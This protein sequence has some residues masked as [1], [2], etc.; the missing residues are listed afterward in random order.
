MPRIFV[1]GVRGSGKSTLLEKIQ[2]ENYSILED[3]EEICR[4]HDIEKKSLNEL[5]FSQKEPML[6]ELYEEVYS[7]IVNLLLDSHFTFPDEKGDYRF[8]E[9]MENEW[10]D[11]FLIVRTN[12]ETLRKRMLEDDKIRSWPKLDEIE[13]Y[14]EKEEEVAR[15]IADFHGKQLKSIKNNGSIEEGKN[16]LEKQIKRID[17]K[18][19]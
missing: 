6:E 7:E 8:Q 3:T 10:Y 18:Y 5:N 9:I 2:I 13:R 4:Y 19:T 14:I 11:E 1:G 16:V 15:Y 12:P 17:R